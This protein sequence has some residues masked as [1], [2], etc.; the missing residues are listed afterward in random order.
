MKRCSR[1]VD[2]CSFLIS[3]YFLLL[4]TPHSLR[5]TLCGGLLT[6]DLPSINLWTGLEQPL[7]RVKRLRERI[8][9]QCNAFERERRSRR[10][11]MQR[12]ET[13]ASPNLAPA[14]VF[15]TT[16]SRKSDHC[17]MWN[18]PRRWRS[19]GTLDVFFF[20][21]HSTR[22]IH[23]DAGGLARHQCHSSACRRSR[24]RRGLE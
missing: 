18:P 12:G 3:R 20:T 11:E 2:R 9:R 21:H 13:V 7:L 15:Y 5:L 19:P 16:L 1:I 17:P 14:Q 4:L 23:T 6:A 22:K 24:P 8:F 10:A